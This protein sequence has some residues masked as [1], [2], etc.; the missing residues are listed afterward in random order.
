MN[1]ILPYS[2][3]LSESHPDR[4]P[5][6]Y[7]ATH[8]KTLYEYIL[9]VDSIGNLKGFA[10]AG[11]R[12]DMMERRGVHAIG[13]VSGR[14]VGDLLYSGFMSYF[15]P[16]LPTR[17]ESDLAKAAWRRKHEDPSW[18]K[19]KVEGLGWYDRYPEEDYLNLVYQPKKRIEVRELE[20]RK[21]KDKILAEVDRMHREVH[22]HLESNKEE[23]YTVGQSRDRDELLKKMGEEP[24]E[25]PY[26][27]ESRRRES[28][29][30]SRRGTF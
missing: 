12:G 17:N 25:A 1:H 2:E 27:K 10:T 3:F 20:K 9:V 29:P 24:T 4:I 11:F 30:Q 19:N 22:T 13:T 14:G 15:G 28:N 8:P 18:I 16:L 5:I 7:H 21:D 23:L 26:Q 6:V